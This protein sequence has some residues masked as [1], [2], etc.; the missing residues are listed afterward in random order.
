MQLTFAS[1]N[2]AETCAVPPVDRNLFG[3]RVHYAGPALDYSCFASYSS[4]ATKLNS[5]Q[6]VDVRNSPGAQIANAWIIQAGDLKYK[7]YLSQRKLLLLTDGFSRVSSAQL[8]FELKEAGFNHVKFLADGVNT[9]KSM[10]GERARNVYVG[11]DKVIAEMPAGD[12]VF[13]ASVKQSAVLV[14]LGVRDIVVWDGINIPDE[15]F[16][17]ANGGLTPVVMVPDEPVSSSLE[18]RFSSLP[19]FYILS[20]GVTGILAGIQKNAASNQS[21]VKSVAGGFCARNG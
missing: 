6:L 9:W 11:A 19:G 10:R 14:R 3:A 21:R 16:T 15:V 18:L 2:Q 1:E 17:R 12:L 5:Y 4:L 8:C 13:L 20:G 7:K